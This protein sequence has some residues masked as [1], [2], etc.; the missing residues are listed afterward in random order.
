MSFLHV[1]KCSAPLPHDYILKCLQDIRNYFTTLAKYPFSTLH[2]IRHELQRKLHIVPCRDLVRLWTT[3][4]CCPSSNFVQ[5]LSQ[6]QL[7]LVPIHKLWT[8]SKFLDFVSTSDTTHCF[9]SCTDIWLPQL[10]PYRHSLWKKVNIIPLGNLKITSIQERNL[11]SHHKIY[12][13]PNSFLEL[14]YGKK[15]HYYKKKHG[16]K[17]IFRENS[18]S[19]LPRVFL[20]HLM[21]PTNVYDFGLKS[22]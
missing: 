17:P 21:C 22:S 6:L 12:H 10:T 16:A 4:L 8:L 19:S 2:L 5:K 1:H 14:C 7:F 3:S 20:I 18:H 13:G 9:I 15:P 11:R